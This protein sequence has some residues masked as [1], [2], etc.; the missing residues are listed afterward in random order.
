MDNWPRPPRKFMNIMITLKEARKITAAA[1]AK[2][3]EIG[4][5]MNIAVGDAG[6]WLR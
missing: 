4:Q 1:E 2:A 3:K 5:P 6:F